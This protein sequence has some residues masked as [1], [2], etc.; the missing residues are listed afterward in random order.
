MGGITLDVP[1]DYKHYEDNKKPPFLSKFP[2][3]KIPALEM[4]DGFCLFESTPVAKYGEC[5]FKS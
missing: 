3:G 2:H 1:A 4:K 5:F